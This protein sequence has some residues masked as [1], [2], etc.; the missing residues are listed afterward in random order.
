MSLLIPLLIALLVGAIVFVLVRYAMDLLKIPQ[1][2]Y[3]IVL[4][5]L[6]LIIIVWI[7]ERSGL[8]NLG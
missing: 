6:I 1:P 4:V 8:V 2:L 3:N 5:I 7:L